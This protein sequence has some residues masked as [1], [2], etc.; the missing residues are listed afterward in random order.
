MRDVKV[1]QNEEFLCN[2][3]ERVDIETV[4]IDEMQFVGFCPG[5]GTTDSVVILRQLRQKYPENIQ[6]TVAS[7]M[8]FVDSEKT[9]DS[10]VP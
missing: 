9:F 7:Y 2:S 1:I 10:R 4:N 6:K 5:C 3:C 8:A